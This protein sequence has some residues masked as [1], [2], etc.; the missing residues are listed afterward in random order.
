MNV[1]RLRGSCGWRGLPALRKYLFDFGSTEHVGQSHLEEVQS[2][3]A[4]HVPQG[5]ALADT[6]LNISVFEESWYSQRSDRFRP[7]RLATKPAGDGGPDREKGPRGGL[8]LR[9][10]SCAIFRCSP[11]TGTLIEERRMT[12]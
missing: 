12:A 1:K 2:V 10:L 6:A 5:S 4:Q 7:G 3:G 11:R 9:R 8:G